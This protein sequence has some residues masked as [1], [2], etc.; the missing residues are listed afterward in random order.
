[1]LGVSPTSRGRQTWRTGRSWSRGCSA[2]GR[3]TG[4]QTGSWESTPTERRKPARALSPSSFI[5]MA[6]VRWAFFFYLLGMIWI[7]DFPG[8][9]QCRHHLQYCGQRR[10]EDKG[11]A[12]WIHFWEELAQWQQGIRKVG[13][14]CFLLHTSLSS[15]ISHLCV[16]GLCRTRSCG[17]PSWTFCPTTPWPSSARSPSLGTMWSPA[18]PPSELS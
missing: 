7:C 1:M 12:L 17:T 13:V 4:K 11:Q 16:P 5:K 6:T 3:K 8:S 15:P 14:C 18:A 9:H 2:L 10:G